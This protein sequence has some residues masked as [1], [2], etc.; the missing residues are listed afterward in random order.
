MLGVFRSVGHGG[1]LQNPHQE[2]FDRGVGITKPTTTV[3]HADGYVFWHPA[4]IY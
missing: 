1:T 4:V 3:K 2:R